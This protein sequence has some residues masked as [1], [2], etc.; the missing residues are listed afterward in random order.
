L[1]NNLEQMK[2]DHEKQ[3]DNLREEISQAAS[4]LESLKKSANELLIKG[5]ACDLIRHADSIRK[6]TDKLENAENVDDAFENVIVTDVILSSSTGVLFDGSK[7]ILGEV[8][9]KGKEQFVNQRTC[10]INKYNKQ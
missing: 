6:R 9:K 8:V 2:T 7:S 4:L 10:L 5:T 1:I 3:M